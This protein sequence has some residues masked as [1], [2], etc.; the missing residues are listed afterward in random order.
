MH[1]DRAGLAA[2]ISARLYEGRVARLHPDGDPLRYIWGEEY[3]D[4]DGLR[5]I[6]DQLQT[7]KPFTLL[8]PNEFIAR[9]GRADVVGQIVSARI[10]G[11]FVVARI[12]ITDARAIAA[13]DAGMHE[14]SLGYTSRLDEKSRQRDIQIDHVALVPRAR[15]GASCAL[16]TDNSDCVG[17]SA[18]ACNVYAMRYNTAEMAISP[19][20]DAELTTAARHELP[21]H[22]FAAVESKS[23]PLEDE[24]H[25][26][27]AM[28]RFNQTDFK[29]PGERK[30]AYHHIIA[31]A[32][33]L[34]MDPGGF[35]KKYSGKLDQGIHMEELQ[36]KLGEALADAASQKVRAD[37][38]DGEL[39][40]ARAS[41]T[42]AEVTA[43]NAQAA[44]ATEKKLTEA[45]QGAATQ[46]KADADIAIAKAKVDAQDAMSGA[47]AA[48]VQLLTEVNAVLG[49]K[50][51]KGQ[52]VDRTSL[53]DQ[54]LRLAVIKHVD[55][56]EFSHDKD[57][58]FVQGVYAGSLARA[59]SAS[60]SRV[61]VREATQAVRTPAARTVN[62][63]PN[64]AREAELAAQKA[65][66]DDQSK[67]WRSKQN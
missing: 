31:R 33:Q 12:L 62:N 52:P 25:V 36:K 24:S 11:P 42:T 1:Q 19:N 30:A 47:V 50:D 66:K 22:M 14:L 49:L 29:G 41:L 23:L 45:A 6:A 27:N 54:S 9:G 44:L 3:R 35:E 10:D 39:R 65:M 34:G 59:A 48:R 43:T 64:A 16:R 53:D 21:P 18:C 67:R 37:Q 51:A 4:A 2:P 7:S 13:I 15:C 46:A 55:N 60:A 38:L 20:S 58:V 26:Q 56:L 5:E 61:S 63:P 32:H 17:V 8:H 57:P 28:A 40:T